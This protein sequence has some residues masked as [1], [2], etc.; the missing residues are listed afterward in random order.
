MHG[1]HKR[2]SSRPEGTN[3][4]APAR[5]GPDLSQQDDVRTRALRG[6]P[7]KGSSFRERVVNGSGIADRGVPCLRR[8]WCWRAWEASRAP[9]GT[10]H[11][12]VSTWGSAGRCVT[13]LAFVAGSGSERRLI[14]VWALIRQRYRCGAVDYGDL[15]DVWHIPVAGVRANVRGSSAPSGTRCCLEPLIP[16]PEKPV[17]PE[18]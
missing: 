7:P 9:P 8:G 14:A 16:E 12:P 10:C 6:M 17:T 1:N 18:S 2:T 11:R 5:V 13:E 3:V 4:H 15:V